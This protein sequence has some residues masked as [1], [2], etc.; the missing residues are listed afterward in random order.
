MGGL[1]S[2]GQAITSVGAHV[3][4]TARQ[5]DFELTVSGDSRGD[6]KSPS[7]GPL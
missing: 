2:V 3:A 1:L 4:P 5:V 6:N 7:V